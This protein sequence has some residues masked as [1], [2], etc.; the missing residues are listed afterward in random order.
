MRGKS[1]IAGIAAVA[2]VVGLSVAGGGAAGA[3]D[4]DFAFYGNAAGARIH[5][6]SGTVTS[7]VSAES[8]VYGGP[9]PQLD[10]NHAA[11][12]VLQNVAT[13]GGVNT[14]AEIKAV[15]GGWQVMAT[16]QTTGL[17]ILNGAIKASAVTTTATI[18][19]VGGNLTTSVHTKFLDLHI[20]GINVPANIPPN[21]AV[22]LGSIA[23]IGVNTG[24]WNVQN[25]GNPATTVARVIGAGL[26][27]RLLEPAGS[28]ETGASIYA[29]PVDT[30]VGP[31]GNVNTGHTN[32]G[33]AYGTKIVANVGS[34]V[35]FRSDPTAPVAVFVRGTNDNTTS[36]RIAAVRLGTGLSVGAVT[37]TGFGHND[38]NGATTIMTSRVATVNLFSGL[39]KA[40]AVTANARAESNGTVAGSSEIVG[41]TIAGKPINLSAGANTEIDVLHLGQVFINR[42][43]RTAHGITV[44]GLDVVLGT[45]RNGLPAGA[46]VQ[47][48]FAS[49]SAT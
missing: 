35:G 32:S 48:A 46:E 13:V 22:K 8:G 39:I 10:T 28:A 30:I 43:I 21:W 19:E 16:S 5:A 27:V 2:S 45:S 36:E 41:L 14:S 15:S 40:Q 18:T 47:V 6:L 26:Q 33:L 24:T 4:S 12:A 44:I 9:S 31:N 34:L 20:A 38:V 25:T 49:A 11:G 23:Q 1:L 42:Q 7:S 17:N 29:S 3:A 37:D